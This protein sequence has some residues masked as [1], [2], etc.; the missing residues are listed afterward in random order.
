MRK[1]VLLVS[2]LLAS[3]VFCGCQSF[4]NNPYFKVKESGLNWVSIRHYNYKSVPIQ[5]VSVRIDGNGIVTVREGASL[6][7]SN[8]YAAGNDSPYWNDVRETR[9]T[10]P[11]EDVIPIYQM[12]VDRGLF[13]DRMKG[14]SANTNEAIFVSAN[15]QCKTC[16]NEDDIYGSDPELAEH[17]KNV[18]MMFYHPQP[19][20]RR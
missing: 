16:G 17:L 2:L 12:L 14:D 5:R 19:K 3:A 7:V 10:L 11:R 6:L 8:P 4:F 13:K 1:N 15:I 18:V 9:I 20:K